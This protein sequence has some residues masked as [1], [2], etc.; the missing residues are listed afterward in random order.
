MQSNPSSQFVVHRS[1]KCDSP[2]RSWVVEVAPPQPPATPA[3]ATASA[4]QQ[5]KK[6]GARSPRAD[7]GLVVAMMLARDTTHS[8][9]AVEMTSL[10]ATSAEPR[11]VRTAR[12]RS[13]QTNDRCG[14]HALA[15]DEPLPSPRHLHHDLSTSLISCQPHPV[16]WRPTTTSASTARPENPINRDPKS[17]L[18]LVSP[19]ARRLAFCCVVPS[20]ARATSAETTELDSPA[21]HGVLLLLPPV[22]VERVRCTVTRPFALSLSRNMLGHDPEAPQCYQHCPD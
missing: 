18:D 1:R 9:W 16:A 7:G 4:L 19:S 15:R 22:Q 8:T 13:L 11:R 3:A 14:H 12:P 2:P 21:R 17:F 5:L 20:A 10:L 6:V